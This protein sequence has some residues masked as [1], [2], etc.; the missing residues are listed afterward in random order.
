MIALS[1]YHLIGFL[2]ITFGLW[3][4][5]FGDLVKGAIIFVAGFALVQIADALSDGDEQG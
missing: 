1:V 5:C 2:L 3:E 4:A